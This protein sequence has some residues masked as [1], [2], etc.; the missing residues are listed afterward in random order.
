MA[1]LFLV[2]TERL[3]PGKKTGILFPE[4]V[5]VSGYG[6]ENGNYVPGEEGKWFAGTKRAIL[7]RNR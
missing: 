4:P 2:K 3:S 5:W 6:N 1:N 7:F